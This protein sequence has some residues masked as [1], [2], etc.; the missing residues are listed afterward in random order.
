[1]ANF[2]AHTLPDLPYDYHALQPWIDGHS[3][4]MHHRRVHQAHVDG[5]NAALGRLEPGLSTLP[6]DD[7]LRGID[8]V[9]EDSRSAIRNHGGGHANHRLLW[10]SLSPGGGGKPTGALADTID[11]QFGSFEVF[12]DRVRHVGANLFGSGWIW[13]I[14]TRGKLVT[15]TLPNEDSPL[16][17]GE[18]PLLGLDLWEHAWCGDPTEGRERQLEALW[19]VVDWEEVGRRYEAVKAADAQRRCQQPQCA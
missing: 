1:M 15:Y 8:T 2:E 3:L 9:P 5:L 10:T 12:K 11:E 19:N 18:R 6:V 4:E 14:L 13:L 7:L 17:V 16:L